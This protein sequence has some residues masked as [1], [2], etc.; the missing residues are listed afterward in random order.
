MSIELNNE[1]ATK[2]RSGRASE[3]I[4]VLFEALRCLHSAPE[5]TKLPATTYHQ[6]QQQQ[7]E[8]TN[9]K[10]TNILD[11]AGNN[12][13]LNLDLLV[14]AFPEL[15][16]YHSLQYDEGMGTFAE[17][18]TMLLLTD[19]RS[20]KNNKNKN[21]PLIEAI[22]C[23]NLGLASTS[24]DHETQSARSPTAALEPC[25][26][27]APLF[28]QKSLDCVSNYNGSNPSSLLVQVAALHNIGHI[29]CRNMQYT[30][31]L[32]VYSQAHEILSQRILLMTNSMDHATSIPRRQEARDILS[33][34]LVYTAGTC[35]CIAVS[36]YYIRDEHAY[37]S[38]GTVSILSRALSIY[39]ELRALDVRPRTWSHTFLDDQTIATVVNNIGRVKFAAGDSH[40]ALSTYMEVLQL[41]TAI[42]GSS[43]L[44]VGVV[45]FNMAEAFKILDDVEKAKQ[46]YSQYLVVAISNLGEGHTDVVDVLT[47]LG[48]LCYRSNDLANARAFYKR[49]LQSSND[50]FHCASIY[51]ELGNAAVEEGNCEEALWYYRSGLEIEMK[52]NHFLKIELLPITLVNIAK[53]CRAL[54]RYRDSLIHYTEALPLID[55]QY[56]PSSDQRADVLISIA[57]LHQKER[58]YGPAENKLEEA[59]KIRAKLHGKSY[60]VSSLLNTLGTIQ[61][62]RKKYGPALES[63]LGSIDIR[64]NSSESSN[65]DISNV[66][67]NAA[68]TYRHLG[69]I[70]KA[71]ICFQQSLFYERNGC[72]Q[73]GGLPISTNVVTT[74]TAIASMQMELGRFEEA[75]TRYQEI[76]VIWFKDRDLVDVQIQSV[77]DEMHECYIQRILNEVDESSKTNG[78]NNVAPA[79]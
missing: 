18:L 38:A 47:T 15:H 65:S 74:I 33:D 32:E 42:L 43:H 13:D 64:L 67:Y 9:E 77:Y 16:S 23:F 28:F 73:N 52:L 45:L 25:T 7:L 5:W 62:E 76:V 46:Y 72:G 79:A 2:L 70:E 56:G 53:A 71:L 60:A 50:H 10:N 51:N 55:E 14:I 21:Q 31:A 11:V 41:R 6:Q 78:R 24:L 37:P 75:L 61:S 34:V 58:E 29:H 8:Q 68:C 63:F 4:E 39:G 48:Q 54:S 36:R 19:A 66:L 30:R 1:A 69:E 12:L 17:P 57:Q 59:I 20:P 3:S 26:S 44:D 27:H 49:A 22:I 40:G 35:N